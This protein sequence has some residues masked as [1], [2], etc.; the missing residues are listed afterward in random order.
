MFTDA[1]LNFIPPGAPLSLVGAAGVAIRSGVI[2]LFGVGV[3][4]PV[5][6]VI[7]NVTLAGQ[8]GAMGVGRQRLELFV[9]ITTGLVT[10]T[11]ATLT[12]GQFV[13]IAINL[14]LALIWIRPNG[15]GNEWN[16]DVLANQDPA[17]AHPRLV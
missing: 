1:L 3:G 8:A 15:P 17:T 11:A 6:A 16:L 5:P 9:A 7:G 2:D 12:N 4:Q 13:D 10:G 14:P